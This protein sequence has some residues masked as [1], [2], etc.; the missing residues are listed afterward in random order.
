[1]KNGMPFVRFFLLLCLAITPLW[2]Q[3]SQPN[4]VTAVFTEESIDVDG[5]LN[6]PVWR[7]AQRI[8]NFTQRELNEGQ[9]VTE[10]TETALVYDLKNLYIFCL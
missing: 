10:R 7:E 3:I 5:L 1:M 9:P 8:S 4:I 2:A 6:E